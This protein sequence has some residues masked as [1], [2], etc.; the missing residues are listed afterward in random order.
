M[1]VLHMDPEPVEPAVY[2]NLHCS[3]SQIQY[4]QD[5]QSMT[6]HQRSLGA[7]RQSWKCTNGL[8]ELYFSSATS[9]GTLMFTWV[10]CY[11]QILHYIIQCLAAYHKYW[12]FFCISGNTLLDTGSIISHIQ[13]TSDFNC[14]PVNWRWLAAPLSLINA[15]DVAVY[16]F[17]HA[18]HFRNKF[19][20]YSWNFLNAETYR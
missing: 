9:T 16:F 11:F 8:D 7:P 17:S 4:Y 20:N 18:V 15:V 13:I 6:R 5:P 10:A 14:I 3:C 19:Q 12:L 1:Y 2:M